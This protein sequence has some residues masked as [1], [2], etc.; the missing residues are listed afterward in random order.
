MQGDNTIFVG[1][2]VH[3]DSI[4]AGRCGFWL[5][6][7]LSS[8]GVGCVVV[9]PSMIPQRPGDRIKTDRRDARSLALGL[10]AGTPNTVHVP[11]PTQEASRD[12]VRAWQQS[13]RDITA[14]RQRLL[15]NDIRYTGRASGNVAHRCWLSWLGLVPDKHSSGNARRQEPI[16]RCGNRWREACSSRRCGRTAIRLRSAASSS[17]DR[18]RSTRSSGSRL[19]SSTAADP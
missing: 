15:R 19:E 12:V 18:R 2:D 10:R 3:K 16:T 9:V 5:H 14:A 13:K 4:T 17:S 7:Y 8:K 6:R 11:T 1:L